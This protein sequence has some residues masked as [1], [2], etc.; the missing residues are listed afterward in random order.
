[1]FVLKDGSL[2]AIYKINL[3]EHEVLTE[4]Q[5]LNTISSLKPWMNL[6]ENCTMQIIFEQSPLSPLD[7]KLDDLKNSYSDG[8]DVSKFL[9]EKKIKQIY[10]NCE[11]DSKTRIFER[12]AYLTVR[13]FPRVKSNKLPLNFF[14]KAEATLLSGTS[15]FISEARAFKNILKDL[16]S[17]SQVKLD[18]TSG[19]ELVDHLRKFFNPKSYYKRSFAE[20]NPSVD[21]SKQLIYNLSLIHI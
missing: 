11:S 18:R 6:P 21:I 20:Y 9:F 7:K 16:E 12:S 13:Y 15:D 4:K 3:V 17:S 5:V 10:K 19:V 2:G 1:M 14:K 8:H